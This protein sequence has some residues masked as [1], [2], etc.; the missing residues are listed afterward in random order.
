MYF[1]FD[2]SE[3]EDMVAHLMF[4]AQAVF[5]KPNRHRH[6]KAL[7]IR[8][9]INGKPMGKMLVDGGASINLMPYSTFRKLGKTPDDL[10]KTDLQLRDFG[11]NVFDTQGQ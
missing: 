9:L 5:D 2:E 7:Y 4:T 10:V 6:L 8:G 11:G 1:D 3:Y